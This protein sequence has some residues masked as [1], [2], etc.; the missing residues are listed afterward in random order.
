M[1]LGS[2]SL[3]R[4][5]CQINT[6]PTT[7]KLLQGLTAQQ[8]KQEKERE[9]KKERETELPD[10]SLQSPLKCPAARGRDVQTGYRQVTEVKGQ[11][12]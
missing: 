10:G 1:E 12:H 2:I 4:Q 9:K 5:T 7:N 11:S 6:W 3:H 8:R